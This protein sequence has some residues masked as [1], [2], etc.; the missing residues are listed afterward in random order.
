[1]TDLKQRC[2][3]LY[4][5]LSGWDGLLHDGDIKAIEDFAQQIRNNAL[6][7]AQDIFLEY[8]YDEAVAKIAAAI[9]NKR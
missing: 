2:L 1:M 4:P 8:D 6:L 5:K 3:K 9:E 7:E